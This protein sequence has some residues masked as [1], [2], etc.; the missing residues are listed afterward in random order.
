MNQSIQPAR[1]RVQQ[2]R[3]LIRCTDRQRQTIYCL[4]LKRINS[5]VELNLTPAIK[6]MI[7]KVEHLV[8]VEVINS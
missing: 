6:G 8:K 3:S 2:V 7:S 5:K 1:V 4:G